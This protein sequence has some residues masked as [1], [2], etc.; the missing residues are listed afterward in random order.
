MNSSPPS[1]AEATVR[2]AIVD[3]HT[4][5]REGMRMFV[6]SLEGFRCLW[7][8][9]STREAIGLAET[10]PPDILIVDISLPDRS[11]LEL[12]KDLAA[13]NEE[14]RT[15][16]VSMHDEKLYALRALKA[17]AKGY[18]MKNAP[19]QLMEAALRRV[20]SGG[21]A[22]SAAV[23]EMVMGAYSAGAKPR[24]DEGLH[25]LS[26]REFEVFQMIGE[27]L[28]SSEISER[29]SISPKTVDV[30]RMN[31]RN[32]LGLADGPALTRWA[33]RWTETRRHTGE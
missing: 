21:I 3:D 5:M 26:D 24:P 1:T 18:V 30:H 11:G 33:I 16:V 25:T 31:I 22:V 8:A 17:G 12:I 19:H 10:N 20:A 27:G 29:L 6:D 4:M 2:V 14:I 13:K 23:S 32:K 28:G 7:Q 9:H 15:L